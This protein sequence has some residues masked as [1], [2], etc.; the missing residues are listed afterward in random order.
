MIE[1]NSKIIDINYLNEL[2]TGDLKIE[3]ELM[4]LFVDRSIEKIDKM[5]VALENDDNE[6]WNEASHALKGAAG[7]IGAWDFM[8]L[9]ESAQKVKND[10]KSKK[11][12]IL[13][14]IKIDND[15][16]LNFIYKF[17]EN[18][19]DIKTKHKNHKNKT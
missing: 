17:T 19:I 3:R 14:K 7:A 6:M 1:K 5:T 10:T 8:R 13:D 4:Q 18:N 16:V 9:A 12:K 2:T 11:S 15:L